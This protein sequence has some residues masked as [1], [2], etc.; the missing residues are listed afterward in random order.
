MITGDARKGKWSVATDFIYFSLSGD[1]SA[2][3]SVDFN[4]GTG[5]V[6]VTTTGLNLGTEVKLKAAIWSLVGGYALVQEPHATLDVIGGFRYA[7]LEATTNWRLAATVTGPA[8]AANFSRTGSI[9]KSEDILDAIVGVR[10]RVR[11]GDSNW[12]MP[13]HVD[14]GGGDSKLT[15]QGVVGIAYSYKWGDVG[16]TYRH[17]SYDMGGNKLIEDLSLSGPALGVAFRF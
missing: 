13:Y 1:Q 17:L 11:L 5:P 14:V 16:L 9:K 10:G 6:N 7:G 8:G 12:F 3:K 2:V 15:W 4:P